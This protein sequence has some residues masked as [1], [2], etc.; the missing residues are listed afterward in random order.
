MNFKCKLFLISF[1]HSVRIFFAET[2]FSTSNWL[3]EW[4]TD[5]MKTFLFMIMFVNDKQVHCLHH[6]IILVKQNQRSSVLIRKI[7]PS[8]I[9]SFYHT[10]IFIFFA[11][12]W[13]F[14]TC[15]K[16]VKSVKS[17][18]TFLS[19]AFLA[20]KTMFRNI[21]QR[22]IFNEYG[23]NLWNDPIFSIHTFYCSICIAKQKKKP[24]LSA[25]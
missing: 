7:G 4:R 12:K 13:F 20:N 10:L 3:L 22:T 19:D 5:L 14:R 23:K 1:I 15:N 2:I 8:S 11:M 9:I 6:F 21:N 18:W 16:D 25:N 24:V 17:E